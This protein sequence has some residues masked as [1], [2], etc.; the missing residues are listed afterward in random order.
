MTRAYYW[1]IAWPPVQGAPRIIIYLMT[2]DG[3]ILSGLRQ[4]HIE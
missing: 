3:D 2:F 4:T 1:S